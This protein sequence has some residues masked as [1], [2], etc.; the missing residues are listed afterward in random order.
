MNRVAAKIKPKKGYAHLLHIILS[1][2][3]PL[4][5]YVLVRIEF[6]Q[7][8]LLVVLLSKWRMFAVKPRFW[9]ANVRANAVDLIVGISTVLLMADS[10]SGSWQLFW[11]ALYVI[12]QLGVKPGRSTFRIASQALIGQTYGL[13]ALFA[14]WPSAPLAALVLAGWTICYLSARHYLSSFDEEYMSLFAHVWGFFAAALMWLSSHW[15]IY[16]SVVSQPTLLLTVLGFGLGALYYLDE[17]DRMSVVKK[18][19]IIFIMVAVALVVLVFSD[20]GDSAL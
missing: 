18:R 7:L 8:A 16:Y 20:W 14:V 13:M 3:L 12:W 6:I 15:L 1:A 17:T 4:I 9:P 2:V 11:T 19:Q 10:P 5:V